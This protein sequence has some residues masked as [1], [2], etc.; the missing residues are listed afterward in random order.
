MFSTD[1][2]VACFHVKK[3]FRILFWTV[4]AGAFALALLA[5]TSSRW[6]PVV[7][8]PVLE[9]FDVELESAARLESGGIVLKELSWENDATSL[10]VGRATA[11]SFFQYAKERVS[12]AFTERSFV[13]LE[14]IRIHIDP[15][16]ERPERK[17]E[18]ARPEPV[19]LYNQLRASVQRYGAWAPPVAVENL[20]VG[21]P[22]SDGEAWVSVS[23]AEL[24][25][26]D[27]KAELNVTSFPR[28]VAVQGA[29]APD[30]ATPWRAQLSLPKEGMELRLL[31]RTADEGL[32]LFSEVARGKDRI[33]GEA[34]VREGESL[35]ARA[36]VRSDEFALDPQWL[37]ALKLEEI[38]ALA[39]SELRVVWREDSYTGRL[40]LDGTMEAWKSNAL[41]LEMELGL[42]GDTKALRIETAELTADW[43]RLDLSAPLTFEWKD[44]A[45]EEESVARARLDLA[46][47]PFVDATG[48]LEGALRLRQSKEDGPN[49]GFE[50]SGRNV[51]YEK[52]QAETIEMN[53]RWK[54]E[55]LHLNQLKIVPRDGGGG[56][57]SLN[58]VFDQAKGEL[59]FEYAV[60]LSADWAKKQLGEAPWDNS[61]QAA[62]SI[63]GPLERP[64]VTGRVEPMSLLLPATAPIEVAGA[65][66]FT[67]LNTL[68][69]EGAAQAGEAA[70][71]TRFEAKWKDGLL[72]ANVSELRW[73]DPDYPTLELLEP[74]R[75]EY[76]AA[77]SKR[78]IDTRIFVEAF[79]L[80]SEN[81]AIRGHW[82][83]G[84]TMD[85][86]LRNLSFKRFQPWLEKEIPDID[87]ERVELALTERRPYL[88]GR[89]ALRANERLGPDAR[90]DLRLDGQLGGDGLWV[91]E[92]EVSF[93]GEDSG[94]S[95]EK[96][97]NPLV[98]GAFRVPLRAGFKEGTEKVY[99]EWI[100]D[101][102]LD[103]KLTAR[104]HARFSDWLQQAT[105]L[106]VE[107]GGMDL[108][109][110]GSVADPSAV[111]EASAA[112]AEW[113]GQ[114]DDRSIP[115]VNNLLLQ[116]SAQQDV[117]AIDSLEFTL[118]DSK[119]AG[120]FSAPTEALSALLPG[121]D[122]SRKQILE[123]SSGR[124]E[125][126]NWEAAD[127]V[128]LLPPILR[129][130]G[131]L[132]GTFEWEPGFDF[133]GA[134][135]FEGFGLRPT[136]VLPMIDRISGDLELE[137]RKLLIETASAHFGGS[138][139]RLD[140]W[141]DATDFN[142][143]LWEITVQGNNIPLVRTTDMILRSD[144]DLVASRNEKKNKPLV[145]G[146][147]NLRSSTL[148]M[149]FDPLSPNTEKGPGMAPPYFSIET[150]T[151][152]DWR[153]DLALK[154]D[155]FMRVQSP[156][157]RT[158][159]SANLD[160]KG[161]FGQPLLTGSV[162]VMGGMLR[163]PGAKM[164]LDTGEAYIEPGRPEELQIDVKGLARVA[165]Y[166]ITMEVSQTAQD[167]LIQFQSTPELSNAEIVRLLSTG[168]LSGGGAGAVG[169]Y[170]GRGLLGAGGME[171]GFAD[172]LTVNV[173]EEKTQ[174]GQNTLEV[175]YNLSE[176]LDI[177]GKYDAFDAYNLDLI[178]NIYKQ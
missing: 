174:S 148:L 176:P 100:K 157:F 118:N 60:E 73:T 136:G 97:D 66:R 129:Q 99:W 39:V 123:A 104:S 56:F 175:I 52:W 173:G 61:M 134:L 161:T 83:G 162:R 133:Q 85:L 88:A 33:T 3:L 105:G 114:V 125:L 82:D 120:Q 163:F 92:A 1:L 23:T 72:S 25:D 63:T 64:V 142:D 144:L 156:Y 41:P 168:S 70:I 32:R 147:L 35:P 28:T 102:P 116:A 155:S 90:L 145:A 29:L 47:Q 127:W 50:I 40:L 36:T 54:K 68:A 130:T 117:V 154:G 112:S 62:G 111:L 55:R 94:R 37:R 106:R 2:C 4:L 53:G 19:A 78:P 6:L 42:A 96:P 121:Q 18:I 165:P 44:F 57:A 159:L 169:L 27:F 93:S 160:L 115:K 45:I 135:A 164:S 10:S 20:S 12:G 152:R 51:G 143:V 126:L 132:D 8:P 103:G 77:A 43:G 150:E 87:V 15:A 153:F 80:E 65:F 22:D 30:P 81:T 7:L 34:F 138:P 75:M 110:G 79:A 46:R 119:V 16:V 31:L 5:L 48:N 74:M 59:N 158:N 128:D 149:E 14:N 21:P 71:E 24:R 131:S 49:I 91:R 76:H 141:V 58:G 124:I 139:V 113:D 109:L 101:A 38:S 26:F 172:R 17:K 67:E 107:D 11:P 86:L 84:D 108:K 122:G 166:V 146:D 167:P 89:V 13:R 140:G 98:R 69:V 170:L 171:G 177:R 95:P 9:R 178:W 137:D 151:L